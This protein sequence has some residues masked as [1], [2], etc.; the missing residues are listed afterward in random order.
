MKFATIPLLNGATGG[1]PSDTKPA[2]ACFPMSGIRNETMSTVGLS[3]FP[4]AYTLEEAVELMWRIKTFTA[5]FHHDFCGTQTILVERQRH[6]VSAPLDERQLIFGN[7]VW[8]GTII[9]SLW[10]EVRGIT[11]SLKMFREPNTLPE[12]YFAGQ[13]ITENETPYYFKRDGGDLIF[14]AMELSVDG[15]WDLGSE[16]VISGSSAHNG[17]AYG[18]TSKHEFNASLMGI[19]LPFVMHIGSFGDGD[20]S[21]SV[22]ATEWFPWAN[23]D[24]SDPTWDSG[25]GERL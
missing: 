21:L 13:E 11:V 15:F 2:L 20:A 24:G 1:T 4:R 22:M 18:G 7:C 6:H 16:W 12:I 10:P 3:P 9:D 8:V 25:T 5:V 19:P 23:A 17:D 14:P